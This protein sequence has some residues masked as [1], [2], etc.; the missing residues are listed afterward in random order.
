MEVHFWHAEPNK[1][2][3]TEITQRLE[4]GA[5]QIAI[6]SA[7]CTRP[8]VDFLLRFEKQLHKDNGSFVVV[9]KDYPTDLCELDRLHQKTESVYVH[10]GYRGHK[11]K[12]NNP[13][14]MHSKVFFTRSGDDC[15]LWTGSHNLTAT[16]MLGLNCEAAVTV[17]G[18]WKDSIF[19][20]ALAHLEQCRD[21][22]TP[23]D[24]SMCDEKQ[25]K[26]LLV[27]A[28]AKTNIDVPSWVHVCFPDNEHDRIVKPK[29]R[30]VLFLYKPDTLQL[31]G[32][33]DRERA[34]S[35]YEGVITGS[36][37]AEH[38]PDLEGR[39]ANYQGSGKW[40]DF[41]IETTQTAEGV[42]VLG[43]SKEP[44]TEP[45]TQVVFQLRK[46]DDELR[47]KSS[48]THRRERYVDSL[49]TVEQPQIVEEMTKYFVSE[50]PEKLADQED[51]MVSPGKGS[52]YVHM[53]K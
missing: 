13:P 21:Q 23:Y 9:A 5:D 18:T 34:H 43:L 2:A 17:K 37:L 46:Q 10:L 8:G 19:K 11:E 50:K 15:W 44:S 26:F 38:N 39:T 3:M 53:T 20:D 6:A 45:A 16:A 41:L 4:Y 12:R 22:A 35:A 30:V 48:L 33:P 1:S 36:G 14:L 49:V 27:H 42:P 28:E 25:P 24:P 52:R 29:I 32:M 31:K 40:P 7:Y 47:F 51:S